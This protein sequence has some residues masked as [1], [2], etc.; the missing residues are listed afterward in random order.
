[1]TDISHDQTQGRFTCTVDG[2]CCELDYRV[3][4]L[5]MTI[6]HTGVP[7]QVGGRGIAADLTRIALDTARGRGWQVLPHC[8]YAQAYIRRHPEYADLLG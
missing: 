7:P 6:L 3:D 1:M 5:R 8:S 4:G 2:Y